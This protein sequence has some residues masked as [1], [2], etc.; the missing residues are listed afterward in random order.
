MNLLEDLFDGDVA[1]ALELSALVSTAALASGA[2]WSLVQRDGEET[3]AQVPPPAVSVYDT[4]QVGV[5]IDLGTDGEPK[6]V[7]RIYL[8]PLLP[9]SEFLLLEL[10]VPLGLLI[11]ESEGVD[12]AP[13]TI[14]VTGALPEFSAIK[15][16]EVGDLVRAVSGYSMVA[17]DA[18]MW[19]PLRAVASNRWPGLRV[20]SCLHHADRPS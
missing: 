12:G 6:G 14:Q 18:P 15:Q 4:E 17:G 13:S 1:A 11:E 10:R 16:V 7:S 20:L 9:R 5:D 2:A 8:K 3:A 19:P